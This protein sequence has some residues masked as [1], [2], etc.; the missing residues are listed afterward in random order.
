MRAAFN[1]DRPREA[2]GRHLAIEPATSETDPEQD[3]GKRKMRRGEEVSA[4]GIARLAIVVSANQ[5]PSRPDA[6][7]APNALTPISGT[8]VHDHVLLEPRCF[9][10]APPD[11]AGLTISLDGT[12]VVIIPA[13]SRPTRK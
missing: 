6:R 5:F 12:T 2:A 13:R 1:L 4:A 3:S 8:S 7:R 11:S 9:L 10:G